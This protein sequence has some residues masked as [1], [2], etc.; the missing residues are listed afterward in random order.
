MTLQDLPHMV[1]F[2]QISPF[3]FSTFLKIYYNQSNHSECTGDTFKNYTD[4]LVLTSS[5]FS[6]YFLFIIILLLLL[7]ADLYLQDSHSIRT[8]DMLYNDH[9]SQV[10]HHSRLCDHLRSPHEQS[11]VGGNC[12]RVCW[13]LIGQCLRA[14]EETSR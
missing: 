1:N 4:S 13:T 2:S 5:T 12:A 8:T 10:L 3:F 9:D 7:F 14:R 11:A 6:I